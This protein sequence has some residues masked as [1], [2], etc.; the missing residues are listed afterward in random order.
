VEGGFSEAI[1]G[2]S[3][4]VVARQGL[5]LQLLEALSFS[6]FSLNKSSVS[7]SSLLTLGG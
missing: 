3:V 2:R 4:A 6:L 5:G 1:L 7:S